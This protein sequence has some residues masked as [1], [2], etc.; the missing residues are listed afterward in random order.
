[1]SAR[2]RL[3]VAAGGLGVAGAV[4]GAH[5]AA[6]TAARP[7]PGRYQVTSTMAGERPRVSNECFGASDLAEAFRLPVAAGKC[8]VARNVVAGGRVD[9]AQTC[10]TGK[11]VAAGAIS[12]TYSSTGYQLRVQSR[13]PELPQPLD[14]R[15][16]AR[17]VGSCP[18]E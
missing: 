7:Q 11:R 16:V 15:I 17:R 3:Y 4:V 13:A 6:V 18:A 2:R 12:G 14:V 8:V 5:A 10:T 9:L 1:M